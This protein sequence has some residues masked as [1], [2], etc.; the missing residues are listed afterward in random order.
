MKVVTSKTGAEIEV[1]FLDPRLREVL[2]MALAERVDGEHYVFPEAAKMYEG[3]T[4]TG[5]QTRNM[6]YY[7][8]KAL[9]ARAFAPPQN[10]AVDVL[11]DGTAAGGRADLPDVLKKVQR[12]VK[13]APF[14]EAKS[15]RI[16]DSLSRVAS[17]KSYRDIE[18][19]TGRKRGV[20]SQDLRD[21]GSVSGFSF[22]RGASVKTGRDIKTLI[23]S[24][25]QERKI[26]AVSASIYGWHNLR[27]TFCCLAFA[28]GYDFEFVSKATGHTLAK[29]MRDHYFNPRR[30]HWRQA[31]KRAGALIDKAPAARIQ[32]A[33]KKISART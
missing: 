1:P 7:R 22:R 21:A 19:E 8:G 13:R 28:A 33:T 26:G 12:A 2:E 17:G 11:E 29:T 23:Q 18:V 32:P 6:I 20:I 16:L 31:M 15:D 9:F 4:A 25:R 14:T 30:D 5:N 24:T 10:D 27:G 3:E